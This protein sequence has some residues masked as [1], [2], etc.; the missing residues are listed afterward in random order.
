MVPEDVPYGDPGQEV[1]MA[2]RDFVPALANV[3]THLTSLAGAKG[4]KPS[5][6]TRFHSV[7]PP[8]IS[9][10]D[11]LVRIQKLFQCSQECFVLCLVYIDR[12]VK[13]HPEFTISSLNIHR[14]LV[15]SVMLAAK[16]FDDIYYSNAHY[17]YVGGVKTKEVNVLEAQFLRLIKWNLHVSPKEYSQYWHH[18]HDAVWGKAVPQPLVDGSDR[19]R[20]EFKPEDRLA[21]SQMAVDTE[22]CPN[23][24]QETPVGSPMVVG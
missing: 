11:Y 13:L 15:T 19:P 12:V 9:I 24:E 21:D 8:P 14:L 20:L 6:V 5:R 3:L 7:K 18:V 23:T 4:S 1:E 10:H 2:G 17:A 16:F 22:K